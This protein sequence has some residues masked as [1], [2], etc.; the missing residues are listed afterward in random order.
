MIFKNLKSIFS[1]IDFLAPHDRSQEKLSISAS[2]SDSTITFHFEIIG[3]P[4]DRIVHRR[5]VTVLSAGL[6]SLEHDELRAM[7]KVLPF[8][9]VIMGY[10]GIPIWRFEYFD[11]NASRTVL[12]ITIHLVSRWLFGDLVWIDDDLILPEPIGPE[13]IEKCRK[14]YR[15]SI[16]QSFNTVNVDTIPYTPYTYTYATSD[17]TAAS[18]AASFSDHWSTW[19]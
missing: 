11:V 7:Y 12:N 18:F 13:M 17:T 4:D 6:D 1:Q 15:D 19:I 10:L 5:G 16:L 8:I 3:A 2:N 9:K 14:K